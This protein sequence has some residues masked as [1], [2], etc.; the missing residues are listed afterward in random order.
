MDTSSTPI[1]PLNTGTPAQ[2]AL[3][4]RRER[5][6]AY[7]MV[8]VPAMGTVVALMLAW[9]YGIGALEL[10]LLAGMYLATGLGVEVGM[11]RFF[12]HHAFKAGPGI[13][14]LLGVLGSMAAQGP[15]LFWTATHRQHHAFTDQE[16]DPHSPQRHGNGLAGR[17]RGLWHAHI[18]WL[19]AMRRGNWITFVPD[20]L[21]DRLV[22][23][24]SQWYFA[25][26]GLGLA[27]PAAMGLAVGGTW[28]SALSGL[29]WGGLVR[30]F[31]VDQATWAV[32]SLAH[33]GG[34][35]P[36]A[37]RD[38]S[39]NIAWLALLTMG[40]GWHNNH[41]AFP[42]LAR[43]GHKPWQIDLGGAAIE[44]LALL[45]LAWDV[46]RHRPKQD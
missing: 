11:H 27:L 18:G 26:V 24:L 36:H 28:R 17:L 16:D 5:R 22:V 35:R 34:P 33:S 45:G 7:A 39:R 32:N 40:G 46:R 37:T 29:L 31:L 3:A 9:R 20:L 1:P 13:T 43:T 41:H 12:S 4:S 6:V 19:F 10:G 42:A 21:R 38:R 8:V 15:V 14:A 44:L 23:K 2:N 30:I 25:W